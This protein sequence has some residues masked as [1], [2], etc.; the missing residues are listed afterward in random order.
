[1]ATPP[2]TRGAGK[3]QQRAVYGGTPI[4]YVG[5]SDQRAGLLEVHRLAR[6]AR[7]SRGQRG[8]PSVA[9]CVLA[10]PAVPSVETFKRCTTRLL[11]KDMSIDSFANG[12]TAGGL[13]GTDRQKV[14]VI[15]VGSS[16]RPCGQQA[17]EIASLWRRRQR[18]GRRAGSSLQAR[19]TS[20]AH[21][22]RRGAAS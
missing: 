2:A 3:A 22:N 19:E 8:R 5:L 4:I 6:C 11:K 7:L 9:C 15:M 13:P 16:Q 12:W 20:P 17:D 21:T 1:M 18:C 14:D 10:K